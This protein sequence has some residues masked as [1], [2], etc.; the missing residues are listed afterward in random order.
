[1]KNHIKINDFQQLQIDFDEIQAE[2]EKCIG[3]I[4]ATDKFQT[5]PNWVLKGLISMDD[6]INDVTADQKKKMNK[7]NAQAFTKLKQKLKKYFTE[8]GDSENKFQ[9]QIDKYRLNP[10][11]DVVVA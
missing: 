5:L 1:M 6:C 11:E 8:T 3:Q 9:A 2:L 7:L 10:V 4:F